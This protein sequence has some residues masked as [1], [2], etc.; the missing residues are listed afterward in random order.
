MIQ[1]SNP[2]APA[3]NKQAHDTAAGCHAYAEADLERAGGMDTERGRAKFEHSA[4]TW[5]AR[6]DMLQRLDASHAARVAGN[7]Q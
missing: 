6:G 2:A 3:R 4:A 5:Q 7:R 1:T